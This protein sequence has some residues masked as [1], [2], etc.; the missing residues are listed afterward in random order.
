VRGQG[1][2]EEDHRDPVGLGPHAVRPRF[3]CTTACSRVSDPENVEEGVVQGVPESRI[4]GGPARCLLEPDLAEAKPGDRFQFVRH[5][6]FIS[7]EVDSRP[8]APSSTA[9][10]ASRTSTENPRTG[11]S[12]TPRIRDTL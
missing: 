3:A 11:T 12:R 8:G 10:S 9:S 6:Y 5:G 2:A 4:G 7:D 1:R